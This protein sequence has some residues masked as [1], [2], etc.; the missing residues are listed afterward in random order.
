MYNGPKDCTGMRPERV[1]VPEA[2]TAGGA[3]EADRKGAA[4][5]VLDFD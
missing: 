4:E 2:A 5:G 3:E 1:A